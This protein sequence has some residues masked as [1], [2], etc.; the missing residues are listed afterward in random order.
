[1]TVLIF[2]SCE[3]PFTAKDN[4]KT[5][6]LSI[7][8][9][10]EIEVVGNASTGYTWQVLPYDSTVIKQVGEPTFKSNNGGKIGSPGI[11]TFKFQT[12][13]EGQTNLK[14]IYYR[15]WEKDKPPAKT[16][17]MNILVGTM[18]RILNDN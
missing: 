16:F 1:M 3:E 15:K 12:I 4:G 11:I 13:A 17:D 7:D 8:D 14:L 2:N 5:V 18:G 9:K 10:F 6:T